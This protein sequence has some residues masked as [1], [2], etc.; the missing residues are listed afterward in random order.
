MCDRR[1]DRLREVERRFPGMELTTKVEDALRL[2]G[3]DAAVVCTSATVHY[4]VT[5]RCL[6]ARK[7]VLVEKPMTTVAAEAVELI[8][9]AESIRRKS[10][11]FDSPRVCGSCDHLQ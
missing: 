4:D 7:H 3:V 2:D 5:R 11:W 8:A 9:L 6:E 1:G 10:H